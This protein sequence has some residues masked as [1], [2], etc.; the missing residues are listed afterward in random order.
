[1]PDPF[2]ILTSLGYALVKKVAK[3]DYIFIK[4]D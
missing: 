4:K 1:M 3:H 2:E